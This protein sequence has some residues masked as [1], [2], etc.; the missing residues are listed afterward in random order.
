MLTEVKV[1]K[2]IPYTNKYKM[3]N[4]MKTAQDFNSK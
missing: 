3:S 2:Y 4:E 1:Y